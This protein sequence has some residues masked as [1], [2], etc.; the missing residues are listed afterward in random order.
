MNRTSMMTKPH[1]SACLLTSLL[2][3]SAPSKAAETQLVPEPDK[4]PTITVEQP[5]N[6]VSTKP[7]GPVL[8]SMSVRLGPTVLN[9][10]P[11]MIVPEFHFIA[12]GGNAVL[13]HRDMVETSAN[14]LHFN[15]SSAINVPADAQKKGAIISGG[16]TCNQG[17]Y[18]ATVSAYVMDSDGTRSNPIKYTVHCNGG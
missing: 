4:V 14:N 16:W 3:A 17:Q 11:K 10:P 18:Y 15:P 7:G 12:P 2:L 9:M 5:K 13:L 6:P 1:I 8:L